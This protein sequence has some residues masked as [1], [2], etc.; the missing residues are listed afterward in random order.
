MATYA[1][2]IKHIMYR[3]VSIPFLCVCYVSVI[4][5]P[6]TMH[7]VYKPLRVVVVHTTRVFTANVAANNLYPRYT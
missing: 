3:C 2:T 1:C 4:S 6:P 7:A 5:T